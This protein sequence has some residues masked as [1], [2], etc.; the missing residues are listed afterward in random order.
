MTKREKNA[1]TDFPMV[2]AILAVQYY[3]KRLQKNVAEVLSWSFV[4][5]LQPRMNFEYSKNIW[6]NLNSQESKYKTAK[7]RLFRNNE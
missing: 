5:K 6:M 4:D 1:K 2:T 7:T 3:D